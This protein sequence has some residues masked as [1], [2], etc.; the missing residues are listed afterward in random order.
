[1]PLPRLFGIERG[2]VG[3][4]WRLGV[5]HAAIGGAIAAGDVTVQA[6]FLARAGAERLP[7]VLLARAILG[8]AA[9]WAYA[10]MTRAG[11]TRA[12]LAAVSL[13]A[14]VV[15]VGSIPLAAEG[16]I[17][18][19]AAYVVHETA[20]SVVTIHWGV[21]LLAHVSGA[22]ARRTTPLVYG[23]ARAGAMVA[24]LAL[25]PLA[26]VTAAEARL[27]LVAGLYTTGAVLCWLATPGTPH[28]SG[29]P[30]AIAPAAAPPPPGRIG[31][32]LRSP[33]LV[34]IAASTAAMVFVRFALRYQQ[35]EVLDAMGEAEVTGLLGLY[36]A[37]ASAAALVLHAFVV[38]RVVH[39]LGLGRTN[40]LYAL[41]SAAA[42]LALAIR[43]GTATALA[44]RFVDGE[45]KAALKT[46][47]SNLFYEP[48][49][50]A[51]RPV[52]R[53]VVL[54]LISP[55]A[56]VVGALMLAALA[57][58][59]HPASPAVLGAVACAAFFAL[60]LAQNR[61]YRRSIAEP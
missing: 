8:A 31:A 20:S 34:A 59:G 40:T 28:A 52:A 23:A 16:A 10:R 30:E 60:T 27:G 56:Q 41:V 4:V 29:A 45:L 47:L 7:E 51:D 50:A 3:V 61:A 36:T 19:V 9:T 55:A 2:D 46:P 11:S 53:A 44:A 39:R 18:P 22:Q 48:F 58:G 6:I 25:A 5:V 12:Q 43:G 35:Q 49:A 17:G 24:G 33:L 26:A 13:V 1:M 37:A 38:N 57:A 32:L 15:A 54:G 21:F 14:A 42:Q